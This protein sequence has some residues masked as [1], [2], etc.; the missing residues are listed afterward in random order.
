MRKWIALSGL[1]L[2]ALLV[3]IQFVP[4]TTANPPVEGDIPTSLEVKAVLRRAC[5]DCHSHETVWPWYGQIAPISWIIVRD[6]QEG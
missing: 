3:A 6:V 5:Y 2:I 4:V 1:A